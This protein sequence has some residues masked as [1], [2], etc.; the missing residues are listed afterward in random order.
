MRRDTSWRSRVS[1]DQQWAVVV[2][3]RWTSR[4]HDWGDTEIVL[5]EGAPRGVDRCDHRPGGRRWRISELLAEFPSG[6]G[7]GDV[8]G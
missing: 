1:W 3:P 7:W 4:V 6:C 2:A 5:P 8:A